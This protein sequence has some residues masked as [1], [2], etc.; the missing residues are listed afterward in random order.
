MDITYNEEPIGRIQ[1]GDFLILGESLHRIISFK[2][3]TAT[4][5]FYVTTLDVESGIMSASKF[6]SVDGLVNN[7]KDRY[8]MKFVPSK[9]VK[10]TVGKGV[11]VS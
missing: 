6:V 2:D 10:L 3:V 7:Y 4:P 5:S 11:N 9:N 8:M 1:V